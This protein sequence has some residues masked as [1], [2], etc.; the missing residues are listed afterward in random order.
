MNLGKV[1]F[2]LTCFSCTEGLRTLLSKNQREGV[3]NGALASWTGSRISHL[4]FAS[5]SLL[6]VKANEWECCSVRELLWV[7]E[8]CSGQMISYHKIRF[9]FQQKYQHWSN[10]S[11]QEDVRYWS[12]NQGKK[13]LGLPILIG[14]GKRQA[15]REILKSRA[16]LRTIT[17][18][19]FPKLGRR[20]SSRPFC[21]QYRHMLCH[22]SCFQKVYARRWTNL[23]IIIG[24]KQ[25]IQIVAF[26][27]ALMVWDVWY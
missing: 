7:C 20:Y 24:G 2:H 21:K 17:G 9:V 16:E 22:V 3:R 1:H 25:G 15:F 10:G 27:L 12:Y 19:G 8:E 26:I 23:V 5:N 13:Y 6:F 14:R 18:D 11:S 4:F